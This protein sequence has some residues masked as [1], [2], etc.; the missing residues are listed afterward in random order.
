MNFTEE[1]I[2]ELKNNKYVKNVTTKSISYTKEFKEHFIEETNKGKGPTRVFI[3]SGFNPYIIGSERI[4]SFSKRTKRKHRNNES[5]DDNRGK[6]ST[7]RHKKKKEK[8]L[9][10]EEEIKQL[11]H[12]NLML[13]AENELLK[14]MGFLVKQKQLKKLGQTKD[15][16]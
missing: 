6:K 2:L 9:S 10:T 15:I 11:R 1:Q 14:K 16:N 8:E 7:G 4:R 12:E 5:F 3:E 13:K